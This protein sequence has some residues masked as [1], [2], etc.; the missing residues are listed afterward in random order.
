MREIISFFCV[1]SNPAEGLAD[2]NSEYGLLIREDG[3][4][5]PTELVALVLNHVEYS[6]LNHIDTVDTLKKQGCIRIFSGSLTDCLDRSEVLISQGVH[7]LVIS[8]FNQ[9]RIVAVK[10]TLQWLIAAAESSDGVSGVM[11]SVLT[12]ERVAALMNM[13]PHQT[14]AVKT[15]LHRLLITLMANPAFKETVAI[16]YAQSFAEIAKDHANGIGTHENSL[17]GLSVQ[18]LNREVFCQEITQRYGFFKTLMNSLRL[19]L[20]R[21]TIEDNLMHPILVTRKYLPL[22]ADLKIIFSSLG[23]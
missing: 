12:G 5:T 10:A 7:S 8:E 20:Q 14:T 3:I 15:L 22:V 1:F 4:R 18:F 9:K 2:A 6:D 16:A 17:F 21:S 11:C 19:M 13:D 23:G